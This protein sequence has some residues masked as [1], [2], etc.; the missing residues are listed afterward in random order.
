GGE[1]CKR[2]RARARS[3]N[4]CDSEGIGNGAFGAQWFRV[5]RIVSQEEQ[6]NAF[7]R[8]LSQGFEETRAEAGIVGTQD[9]RRRRGGGGDAPVA[10]G[11]IVHRVVKSRRRDLPIGTRQSLA[12]LVAVEAIAAGGGEH[13]RQISCCDSGARR[14]FE[15]DGERQF[16]NGPSAASFGGRQGQG[17]RQNRRSR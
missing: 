3:K 10:G 5:L 13:R 1:L 2:R 9:V 7:D 12:D 11:D 4:K 8:N 6:R 17:D 15:A 14:R 16:D